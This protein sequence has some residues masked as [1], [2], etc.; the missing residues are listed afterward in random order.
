MYRELTAPISIQWALTS[1]CSRRCFYC[2][3]HWRHDEASGVQPELASTEALNLI[4]SRILA[5]KVFSVT[6]TGG[7]PLL[8]MG[9]CIPQLQRLA[10]AGISLSLNSTMSGLSRELALLL[11]SIGVKSALVSLPSHDPET[12]AKITNSRHSWSLTAEGIRTAIEAGIRIQANMVVCR[13]NINQIYQTAQYAK[14]LGIR[15]FAATKM[16]H[17]AI[18]SQLPDIMLTGNDFQKMAADLLRVKADLGMSVSTVQAYAYCAVADSEVR[19]QLSCFDRTCSAGKTFCVLAPNGDVSPCPLVPEVYGNILQTDGLGNAWR[20]MKMWRDDTFLP[21]QCTVCAHKRTCAGGCRY[22]AYISSGSY[23]APDPYCD[24]RNVP[25]LKE[26]PTI[27]RTLSTTFRP[28]PG[29]RS[30]PEA[31][32]GILYRSGGRWVPVDASLFGIMTAPGATYTLRDFAYSLAVR[33]EVAGKTVGYLLA[34]GFL[35]PVDCVKG[36]GNA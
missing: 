34:N 20:A 14:T 8:V 24:L 35:E 4:V 10:A 23:K 32:G 15:H 27:K 11:L 30:R 16:S 5:A 21:D 7:E 22:D 3:N 36:A 31:F 25:V 18:T 28:H 29:I 6:I 9:H 33:D 26:K 2:A 13:H 1:A 17:P 19:E 12:D